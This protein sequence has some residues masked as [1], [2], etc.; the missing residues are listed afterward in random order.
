MLNYSKIYCCPNSFIFSLDRKNCENN[1]LQIPFYIEEKI[2]EEPSPEE[3]LLSALLK[4][5]EA[6]PEARLFNALFESL[7]K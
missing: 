6:S 2:D 1:L 4:Y 3:R 7:R 5:K